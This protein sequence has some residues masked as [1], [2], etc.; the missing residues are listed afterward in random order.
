MKIKNCVQN[1]KSQKTKSF[2]LNHQV[3]H[4][5]ST[6]AGKAEKTGKRANFG[7]WDRKAGKMY[8]CC[9]EAGKAGKNYT[10]VIKLTSLC[11]NLPVYKFTS[12]P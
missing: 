7:N 12:L 11:T 10:L 8:F 5:V 4:R 1:V 9:P 2:C 3:E 6:G